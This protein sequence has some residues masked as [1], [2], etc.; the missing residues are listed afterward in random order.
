MN[1]D[2]SWKERNN[3]IS[4]LT[5]AQLIEETIREEIDITTEGEATNPKCLAIDDTP[6]EKLIEQ[7][8][9]RAIDLLNQLL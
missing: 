2:Q 3:D 4:N 5:V 7:G 6:K 9:Y 1:L 8:Y